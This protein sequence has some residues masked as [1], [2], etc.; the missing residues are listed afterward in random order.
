VIHTVDFVRS[1]SAFL[2]TSIA[3]ASALF[4]P[5]LESLYKRLSNHRQK[6]AGI[7]MTN[8]YK[9]IEIVLAFMVN[10]PWI[11]AGEHWADD[12]TSTWISMALTIALDLSLNKIILPMSCEP[13]TPRDGVATADC[14]DARKALS[15][16]GFSDLDP[17]SLAAKRLLR[18]RER[19][20]LSLFVLERG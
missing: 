17:Q 14:L 10:I 9:S 7:I 6:L 20:W 13:Q 8:R 2:L 19:T 18:R 3:A 5:S 4:S 11:S 12:E 1:R 16:D 15:L